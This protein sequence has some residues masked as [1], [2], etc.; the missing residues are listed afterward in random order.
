MHITPYLYGMYCFSSLNNTF[1]CTM[2]MLILMLFLLH[3][4]EI[5]RSYMS[6]EKSPLQS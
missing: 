4:T 2:F 6:V 1:V 3:S 5:G